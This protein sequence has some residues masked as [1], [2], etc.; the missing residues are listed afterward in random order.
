MTVFFTVAQT[1]LAA[2]AMAACFGMLLLGGV[3][4]I[5]FPA[6][7]AG[8][9]RWRRPNALSPV[10]PRILGVVSS[11]VGILS[12]WYDFFGY[13]RVAPAWII[14]LSAPAV[15]GGLFA[16]YWS[17]SPPAR[18]ILFLVFTILSATVL[19]AGGGSVFLRS[20]RHNQLVRAAERGDT[21][22][23]MRAIREGADV[24]TMD[25]CTLLGIA[26]SGGHVE[27]AKALLKAG[28]NPNHWKC[29]I[30]EIAV[31]RRDTEMVRVLL[32]AGGRQR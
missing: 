4:L 3:L 6:L 19:V 20:Y 17:T 32:A 2:N 11:S 21:A 1:G 5:G 12:L 15:V 25:H 16:L 30:L 23:V 29:D 10:V 14:A 31:A 27:T 26:V 13:D 18:R 7:T 28:A 8:L 9:A 22:A 24:E